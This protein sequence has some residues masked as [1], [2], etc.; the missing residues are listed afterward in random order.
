MIIRTVLGDIDSSRL[1]VCYAHEHLII[2]RSYTTQM[3]PDLL[4]DSVEDACLELAEFFELGGRALVDTMPCDAGRNVLK[5]AAI[6]RRTGLHVICPTGLHLEKYYPQGH[7]RERL[8][9]G[10]LTR[11]FIADIEEGV[12]ANDY[13]GPLVERTS[14]RAGLI[15]VASGGERLSVHEQKVFEAAAIAHVATGAPVLTHTDHGK[16]AV[17]QVEYLRSFGVRPDRI[18]LSHTDRL[19]DPR[20]HREI[21][22]TGAFVEYDGAFRWK[23]EERNG[24]SANPTLTLIVAMFSEGLGDQIMMGMDAARR[25]YWNVYGGS[26]GMSFLLKTFVPE[27]YRA[28]LGETEV[29]RIF[30]DNPARAFR[31]GQ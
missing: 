15:K 17:D 7:W 21:L 25:T 12:D 1:G 4:L 13:G 31:F 2:D 29:R 6:S 27:L 14:H 24:A 26:P 23:A 19:P 9:V 3:V 10:E 22:R 5:L 16:A 30:V 28:G 18:V 20:Y 8:N 11:L